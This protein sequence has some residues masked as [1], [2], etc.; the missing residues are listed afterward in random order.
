MIVIGVWVLYEE[1]RYAGNIHRRIK[2]Y[3]THWWVVCFIFGLMLISY[4][5]VF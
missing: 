3:R 4:P 1:R 5:K 2:P